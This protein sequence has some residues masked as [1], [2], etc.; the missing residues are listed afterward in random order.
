MTDSLG[1]TV[2]SRTRWGAELHYLLGPFALSAEYVEVHYEDIRIAHSLDRGSTRIAHSPWT[3]SSGNVRNISASAS[4]YVTGESKQLTNAGWKT[5]DPKR[6]VGDGGVGAIEL[7][8]RYG[9]TKADEALFDSS[10]VGGFAAGAPELGSYTGPTPGDGNSVTAAVLQGAH[11]VH[12]LTLGASWTL[13][14]MTRVQLNDVLL[15]APEHD[16]DGDGENDNLLLSGAMS[17]Q[18]DAQKKGIPTKWENA[19]MLRLILRI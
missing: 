4:V 5:A 7:L 1:A 15:V 11:E 8:A 16:R 6:S 3:V 10:K 14:P 19:V 12:E 9:W 13:N 2:G 17:S 18:A